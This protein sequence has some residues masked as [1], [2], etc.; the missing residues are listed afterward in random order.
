MENKKR[1]F[2][3]RLIVLLLVGG[4]LGFLFF[5]AMTIGKI[6]AVV[7]NKDLAAFSLI[8]ASDLDVILINEEA[9]KTQYIPELQKNQLIGKQLA[10]DAMA[11]LPLTPNQL[12]ENDK[13]SQLTNKFEAIVKRVQDGMEVKREL[14]GITIPIT[15]TNAYSN[16]LSP[17]DKVNV[18]LVNKAGASVS[19]K[20]IL[21]NA[22]IVN[23]QKENNVISSVTFAVTP[24]NFELLSFAKAQGEIILGLVSSSYQSL[25]SEQAKIEPASI[26][27]ASMSAEKFETIFN[28]KTITSQSGEMQ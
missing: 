1:K 22:T 2:P 16:D 4:L 21:E 15:G 12:M 24:E 10:K 5:Q 7:L 20:I 8:Q 3:V 11:F 6:K 9:L 13:N 28:E 19:S 25:P 26:N 23:V 27:T 18:G 17:M 14:M